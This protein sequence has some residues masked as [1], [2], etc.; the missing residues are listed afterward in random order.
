M[1]RGLC[2]DFVSCVI[3]ACETFKNKFYVQ[4]YTELNL[5]NTSS[6][7]LLFH[8]IYFQMTGVQGAVS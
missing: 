3:A 5:I 6:T 8:I 1:S 7:D 4:F 2:F